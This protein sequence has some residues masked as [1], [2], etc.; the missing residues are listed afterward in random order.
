[1]PAYLIAHLIATSVL[2]VHSIPLTT[3]IP[4]SAGD[5]SLG[6]IPFLA[7]WY[8]GFRFKW[9]ICHVS[10]HSWPEFDSE[11][12]GQ[13]SAVALHTPLPGSTWLVFMKHTH[14][15]VYDLGIIFAVVTY[16]LVFVVRISWNSGRTFHLLYIERPLLQIWPICGPCDRN[17]R[18]PTKSRIPLSVTGRRLFAV[19]RLPQQ[20]QLFFES[21]LLEMKAKS[22]WCPLSLS[23]S[24]FL[25]L[26]LL[27]SSLT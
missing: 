12:H 6:V 23:L 15:E 21:I 19:R 3:S 17:R 4:T 8:F 26:T 25:W 11:T 1:M 2:V 16:P 27:L 13:T 18:A 7:E 5:H 24:P 22:A 20:T 9:L 10:H 14:K